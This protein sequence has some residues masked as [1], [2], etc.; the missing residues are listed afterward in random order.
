MKEEK[1][2]EEEKANAEGATTE[3]ARC[4]AIRSQKEVFRGNDWRVK[5][6]DERKKEEKK[7]RTTMK[8]RIFW[9]YALIGKNKK[10]DGK[11]ANL[12]SRRR[13]ERRRRS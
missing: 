9:R 6:A 8:R 2:E 11:S 12:F 13:C 5:S 4:I 1:D 10:K 7:K 3:S